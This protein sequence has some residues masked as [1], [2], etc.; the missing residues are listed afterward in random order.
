[1]YLLFAGEVRRFRPGL[2][3]TL[4]HY[5]VLTKE[6]RLDCTLC[7]VDDKD[8]EGEESWGA[9]EVQ[10]ELK[11]VNLPNSILFFYVSLFIYLD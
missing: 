7:F 4:A 11:C 9:G 5:G 8:D 3:Y 2:D 1:M 6:P 10:E